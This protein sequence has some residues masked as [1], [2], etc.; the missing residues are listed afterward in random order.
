MEVSKD[1]S[2]TEGTRPSLVGGIAAAGRFAVLAAALTLGGHERPMQPAH[3]PAADVAEGSLCDGCE[4]PSTLAPGSS[5]VGRRLRIVRE[6]ARDLVVSIFRDRGAIAI[7]VNGKRYGLQKF[8][9][10]AVGE[11]IDAVEIDGDDVRISSKEY[12]HARV[13]RAAIEAVLDKL[14]AS[15]SGTVTADVSA[16][17]DPAPGTLVHAG[18]AAKRYFS[19]HDGGPEAFD[20]TF[21]REDPPTALASAAR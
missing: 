8:T 2:A 7:D 9:G 10:V 5:L 20:V 21:E 17:F 19:G 3:K 6:G 12:G 4:D 14:A 18:I 16:R 15:E 1:H 11:K 13:S